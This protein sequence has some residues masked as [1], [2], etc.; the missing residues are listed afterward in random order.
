MQ[1]QL[2]LRSGRRPASCARPWKQTRARSELQAKWR[3]CFTTPWCCSTCRESHPLRLWR[4][5]PESR[6]SFPLRILGLPCRLQPLPVHYT[7][8]P[9]SRRRLRHLACP[10]N[11]MLFCRC[12]EAALAPLGSKR[13]PP[14][15]NEQL[16]CDEG[17]IP[18]SPVPVQLGCKDNATRLDVLCRGASPCHADAC[19]CNR[20]Q[21]I[22]TRL[23]CCPT[24]RCHHGRAEPF[25]A[26]SQ[27]I[28]RCLC[29]WFA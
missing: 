2:V 15:R 6:S 14:A 7:I 28:R 24:S 27:C 21:Q 16:R 8:S 10:M 29:P 4:S 9:P 25:S 23:L 11:A 1:I 19:P 17:G 22:P 26:F 13:K 20:P 18:D 5:A 12:F 3:I